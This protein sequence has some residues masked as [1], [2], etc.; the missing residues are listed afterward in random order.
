MASGGAIHCSINGVIAAGS[1]TFFLVADGEVFSQALTNTLIIFPNSQFNSISVDLDSQGAET[2]RQFLRK[3]GGP[4]QQ[5]RGNLLVNGI[6]NQT[7]D[8]NGVFE[9]GSGEGNC[10]LQASVL[11]QGNSGQ[12]FLHFKIIKR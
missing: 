5:L 2:A 8:F 12:V 1:A 7:L 9:E 6:N 3:A 10:K 4:V 11:G